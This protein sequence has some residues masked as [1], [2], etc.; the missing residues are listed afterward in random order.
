MLNANGN[1][2]VVLPHN[3]DDC[4]SDPGKVWF[5]LGFCEHWG[6]GGN[7]QKVKDKVTEHVNLES[8]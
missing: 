1:I 6:S 2:N 3:L 5:L 8:C 4:T 7:A